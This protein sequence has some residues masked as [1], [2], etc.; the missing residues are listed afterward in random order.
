MSLTLLLN[1]GQW[2]SPARLLLSSVGG[3]PLEGQ[4]W[5]PVN[6][7]HYPL[8]LG[9]GEELHLVLHCEGERNSFHAR[10]PSW[11]PPAVL[12]RL[13]PLE[14]KFPVTLTQWPPPK[15]VQPWPSTC[16]KTNCFFTSVTCLC[17][18]PR[19]VL[20]CLNPFTWQIRLVFAGLHRYGV[21]SCLSIPPLAL[22]LTAVSNL[23]QRWFTL[24]EANQ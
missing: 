12:L 3:I 10:H 7:T 5:V 13:K 24:P 4:I 17:R 18:H 20:S 16:Y 2:A 23:V 14:D 8:V 22:L 15:T 1:T 6:I 21:V 9:T 11:Y 19:I